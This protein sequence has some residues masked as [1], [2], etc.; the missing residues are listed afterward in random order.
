MIPSA[1]EE[2]DTRNE[3]FRKM[4]AEARGKFLPRESARQ[5]R[6]ALTLPDYS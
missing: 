3:M 2:I 5:I 6:S 4:V 1:Q